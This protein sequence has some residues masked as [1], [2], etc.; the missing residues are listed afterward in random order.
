M[1]TF[2]MGHSVIVKWVL[3]ISAGDL[4]NC[5]FIILIP[6]LGSTNVCLVL[7]EPDLTRSLIFL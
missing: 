3:T 6:D 4:M 2:L 5:Y 1:F 7:E